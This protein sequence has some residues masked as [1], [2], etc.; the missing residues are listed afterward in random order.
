[1]IFDRILPYTMHHPLNW[2]PTIST[3]TLC[4]S[5]HTAPPHYF[6]PQ[7]FQSFPGFNSCSWYKI[8]EHNFFS[9]SY[10]M[11]MVI[12][13]GIASNGTLHRRL[14]SRLS[15][16]FVV[17]VLFSSWRNNRSIP[18]CANGSTLG[19]TVACAISI[20]QRPTLI[21]LLERGLHVRFLFCFHDCQKSRSMV[22]VPFPKPNDDPAV[23]FG[24]IR[25]RPLNFRLFLFILSTFLPQM[26][27]SDSFRL[28]RPPPLH[29]DVAWYDTFL[30]VSCLPFLE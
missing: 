18:R 25:R 2:N 19:V 10:L 8:I 30:V 28:P 16:H 4:P 7:C 1:V 17:L 13:I 11:C 27:Q 6:L 5:S 3:N 26:F 15:R 14:P 29:N 23:I 9:K 22:V 21:S 24:G 12:I 20:P